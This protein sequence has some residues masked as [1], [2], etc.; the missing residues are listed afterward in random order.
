MRIDPHEM[1]GG[2]P[3]MLVRQTLRRLRDYS[4]WRLHHLE[5]AAVLQAGQGRA[6]ANSLVTAG[7]IEA[8][9]P[10]GIWV[11]T[12]AGRTLSIA[13]AAKRITRATANRA[14][15]QFLERVGQV[16]DDSYFLGKVVR[17]VLFGSM[18]RPEIE[19][20]SDVDLAVELANKEADFDRAREQNYQR[21]EA[22]AAK[23][24]QFRNVLEQ[25]GCW[26]WETFRFLKG[27]SRVISLADYRNQ[28]PF[29]LAIPHR[30]LIGEPEEPVAARDPA[31]PPRPRRQRLSGCPF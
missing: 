24:H 8:V 1:I 2:Y 26:Y 21:A 19:R 10:D 15:S 28:K 4:E 31:A 27:G 29:I 13:T 22:L 16:N 5:S 23:G 9:G 30:V 7:L 11:V 12:Q 17:L 18:L 3:S 20:L 14:L 6:L 25:A